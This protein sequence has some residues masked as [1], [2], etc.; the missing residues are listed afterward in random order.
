MQQKP[1][2]Q[3]TFKQE[4]LT[5]RIAW[6]DELNLF[7]M[8]KLRS[9]HQTHTLDAVK[10]SKATKMGLWCLTKEFFN[11]Q[12]PFEHIDYNTEA[13]KVK[14][15][16]VASWRQHEDT[17]IIVDQLIKQGL[18]RDNI[19]NHLSSR[20]SPHR[21]KILRS[22]QQTLARYVIRP[23]VRLVKV[24]EWRSIQEGQNFDYRNYV[25]VKNKSWY[26]FIQHYHQNLID[27]HYQYFDMKEVV[28]CVF[29][30]LRIV[31]SLLGSLF[32]LLV[33]AIK[34][35]E[36]TPANDHRDKV[37]VLYVQ[38]LE[39]DK[40]SDLYWFK[41]SGLK[42]EDVL[43]YA[44]IPY[45]PLTIE[46]KNRI[47]EYGMRYE[48]IVPK[49]SRKKLLG[50][51]SPEVHI[52]PT[53]LFLKLL[54]LV[55]YE[56]LRLT[57]FIPFQKYK[58][59]ALWEWTYMISLLYHECIYEAMFVKHHIKVHY[60]LL[61][62][63]QTFASNIAANRLGIIDIS[64]HWSNY[65]R[66][67][68]EHGKPQD[69]Y[70][71][72]GK[73]YLQYF[74]QSH[75][76]MDYLLYYGYS[77]DFMFNLSRKSSK[78]L[79]QKLINNGAT[80]VVTFYDEAFSEEDVFVKEEF[81][82]IYSIFLKKLQNDPTFGLIIKPKR[83][84]EYDKMPE[85]W[86]MIEDAKKTSRALFLEDAVL[87]NL[88]GQA[89]DLTIGMGVFNTAA[90]EAALCGIPTVTI[91][92]GSVDFHPFYQEGKGTITF[93]H[94]EE[95][96]KNIELMKNNQSPAGFADYSPFLDRIDPFRDGKANE[97]IGGYIKFV[98]DELNEGEDKN[99]AI[100]KANQWYSD[101]YGEDKVNKFNAQ[102]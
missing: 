60:A 2:T 1:Q 69:V 45:R 65:A 8:F 76:M 38:G 48:D 71:S 88:A 25:L 89:A 29:Y 42:P 7:S 17:T 21:H 50:L 46:I 19:T 51:G 84:K 18:F 34:R 77:Y 55:I 27:G 57:C 92:S 54:S 67:W 10:Y 98:F 79:R 24:L 91:N 64:N 58:R 86:K 101:L 63:E 36:Q 90:L 81:M 87:P 53:L 35:E 26:G 94:F 20:F 80:F 75:Y 11:H 33:N 41:G 102:F 6:I 5:M 47:N 43:I 44:R 61:E 68:L 15:E 96:M 31:L 83:R 16:M 3:E 4:R 56:I 66:T 32:Y 100:K 62:E 30:L 82:M 12:L 73:H 37:A 93:D 14:D 85:V 74:N 72:W 78:D 40:K 52:Y 9:V 22:L 23:Y 28:V 95:I 49:R 99:E 59:K 97:R 13:L 39:F 70:F